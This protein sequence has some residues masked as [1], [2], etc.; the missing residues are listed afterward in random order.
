MRALT[1]GIGGAALLMLAG[2]ESAAAQR[3]VRVAARAEVHVGPVR[4]SVEVRNTPTA[5][6]VPHRRPATRVYRSRGYW[7]RAPRYC[8]DGYGHPRYG[9]SR[10][11]DA[12]WL[13][14]SF[15][16]DWFAVYDDHLQF[17]QYG[18][19]RDAGY[20][21]AY[22]L[23]RLLGGRAFNRL[24]GYSHR[25]RRRAPLWGEWLQ[26]DGGG[27]SLAVFQG[28]LPVVELRDQNRDGYVDVTFVYRRAGY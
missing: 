8:R 9:W 17:R 28:N 5:R 23:R 3:N 16:G 18:R 11:V 24:V 6:R 21:D 2:A 22:Q 1:I 25:S 12:G 15:A 27:V 14:P 7:T 19:R 13:R 10:C 4:G 20:L 26:A